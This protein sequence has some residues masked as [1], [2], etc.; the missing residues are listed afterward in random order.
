MTRL[1]RTGRPAGV[2]PR[3]PRD[4]ARTAQGGAGRRVILS[5]AADCAV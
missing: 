4:V 1:V 5:P 3:A 2:Y